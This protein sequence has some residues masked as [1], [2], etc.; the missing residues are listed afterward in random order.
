M[1]DPEEEEDDYPTPFKE[2]AVAVKREYKDKASARANGFKASEIR[3]WA[4]ENNLPVAHKGRLNQS[5]VVAYKN[6][7]S[8]I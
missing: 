6:S 3:K 1:F 7:R 2:T 8:T 4:A 5:V